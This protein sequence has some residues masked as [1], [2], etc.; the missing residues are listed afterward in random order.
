MGSRKAKLTTIAFLFLLA[1][2]GMSFGFLMGRSQ[3]LKAST[4][5]T[6]KQLRV[7]TQQVRHSGAVLVKGVDFVK[8]LLV[9]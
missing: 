8:R 7:V 4:A 1:L 6:S 9:K 5:E 2:S 3:Q